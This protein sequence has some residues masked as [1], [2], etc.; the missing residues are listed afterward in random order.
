MA[1]DVRRLVDVRDGPIAR[2]GTPEWDAWQDYY[3]LHAR[4]FSARMQRQ[5]RDQGRDWPV[6][7]QWPPGTPTA[8]MDEADEH[9][10]S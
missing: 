8:I 1:Q 4:W 3:K 10:R 6:T 5:F 9:R 7:T 2:R